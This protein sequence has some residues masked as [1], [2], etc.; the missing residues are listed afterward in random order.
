MEVEGARVVTALLGDE[1]ELGQ[2]EG[3]AGPGVEPAH[4]V[5]P[6]AQV[7]FGLV[8]VALASGGEGEAGLGELLC[9]LVGLFGG[10][11]SC[12]GVKL[13]GAVVVAC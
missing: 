3:A 4:P 11:P 9:R 5:E 13:A 12:A 8:E 7:G 1:A 6:G 10:E 2:D